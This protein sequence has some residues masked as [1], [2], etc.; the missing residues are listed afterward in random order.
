MGRWIV[1]IETS[2]PGYMLFRKT[3][4]CHGSTPCLLSDQEEHTHDEQYSCSRENLSTVSSY[5][6]DWF[7]LSSISEKLTYS[8][9]KSEH[10]LRCHRNRPMIRHRRRLNLL[11]HAYHFVG[12]RARA[13]KS[14]FVWE[15]LKNGL[16]KH[17]HIATS[18]CYKQR[19]WARTLKISVNTR[20]SSRRI[21]AKRLHSAY[22]TSVT[23]ATCLDI[24]FWSDHV[25][26][27]H[28][29][30]EHIFSVDESQTLFFFYQT[31]C[32]RCSYYIYE[33]LFSF[34]IAF[35]F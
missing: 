4:T 28:C 33:F 11:A 7:V 22:F 15:R 19:R 17:T 24:F 25:C 27:L 30:G 1:M 10:W 12:W 34:N 29:Q 20:Q 31:L 14:I 6:F 23:I 18:H 3:A 26:G 13:N 21:C 16:Y 9:A 2:F 8:I 35:F 5:C 32:K